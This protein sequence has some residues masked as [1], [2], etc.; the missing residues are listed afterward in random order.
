MR[1]SHYIFTALLFSASPAHAGAFLLEPG[2]VKVITEY[3]QSR[4]SAIFNSSG[5]TQ[6]R[7]D[8]NSQMQY[9][10]SKNEGSLYVEAGVRSYLTLIGRMQ[11]GRQEFF[12]SMEAPSIKL[13][14]FSFDTG[15]RLKLYEGTWLIS[16]ENSYGYRQEKIYNT[17]TETP[18]T[19]ETGLFIDAALLVGVPWRLGPYV[20]G[21]ASFATRWQSHYQRLE[22]DM[23]IN[24]ATIGAE[25]PKHLIGWR[26]LLLG[27]VFVNSE[28]NE[29]SSQRIVEY[30]VQPSV[31]LF[32]IDTAGVQIG[33]RWLIYGQNAARDVT[34]FVKFWLDF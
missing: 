11:G 16:L 26:A 3:S 21:F 24:E 6:A 29:P 14:W 23:L 19:T 12:R 25:F 17:S 31:V 22:Q 8:L 18:F 34:I 13:N 9:P 32:P 20:N 5:G 33:A 30:K 15:V 2:E 27:D 4:S 10:E 7:P 1:A 28:V